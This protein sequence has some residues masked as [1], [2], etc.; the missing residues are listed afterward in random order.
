MLYDHQHSKASLEDFKANLGRSIIN[1]NANANLKTTDFTF[2]ASANNFE[3]KV[4]RELKDISG[5]Y[6]LEAKASGKYSNVKKNQPLNINQR[7]LRLRSSCWILINLK[8]NWVT[9]R[10]IRLKNC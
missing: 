2:N 3:P 1:A 8:T 9:R 10:N 4:L 7:C 5:I 6:T